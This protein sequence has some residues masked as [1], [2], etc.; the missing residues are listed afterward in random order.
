MPTPSY[1]WH[2]KMF[3]D[4]AFWREQAEAWELRAINCEHD[5]DLRHR[6]NAKRE[7]ANCRENARE[8]EEG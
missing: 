7:A 4:A 5:G 1:D 2:A 6:D 3:K 8:K